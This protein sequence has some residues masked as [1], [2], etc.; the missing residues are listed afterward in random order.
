MRQT[1]S[2]LAFAGTPEIARIVL[3]SIIDSDQ[4]NI[5]AIFTKPDR[6]SGRGH[7]IKQSE[8]KMCA[9]KNNIEI[10]QPE[11]PKE[12]ESYA[13]ES[14][15]LLLVVAFLVFLRFSI[16]YSVCNLSCS[17]RIKIVLPVMKI[18]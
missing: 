18:S 11:N 5:N 13:L 15:D 2:K 14:Y 4:Y 9:I 8:V 7:K 3:E 1:K 10:F 6:P 17:K 16:F 12:L